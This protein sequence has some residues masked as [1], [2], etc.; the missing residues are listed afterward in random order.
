VTTSSP[1]T[2][3]LDTTLHALG[4]SG[5]LLP[6][7]L[8]APPTG[9]VNYGAAGIAYLYYR[10]ACLRSDPRLL[11]TAD[12]WANRARQESGRPDAFYNPDIEI[13][14]ETV[15][16]VALYH[17]A[18]GVHC[19]QALIS[20]AMGDGSSA[21]AT[22]QQFVAAARQPCATLDL[23]LGQASILIGCATLQEALADSAGSDTAGLTELGQETLQR[24]W[25]QLDGYG[26]LNECSELAWLGIAHGW[27][28]ILYA[29]LRWCQAGS[30]LP[31]TFQAR[32]EQ[33]AACAEPAGRGLC[34]PRLSRRGVGSREP[35]SG[36]CH[37]SAGYVFLWTLA[38]QATR[39]TE[40][41]RLA[42]GAAWHTWEDTGPNGHS[43]CCGLAGRAYALL[44][45]YRCTGDAHWLERARELGQRAVANA[46]GGDPMPYSLY[47]GTVGVALLGADLEQ[48]AA[49]CMPLFEPEG[50]PPQP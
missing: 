8:P 15:G 13:T 41:L 33:L 30:L 23:T 4:I 43:L 10:L 44:S 19:V 12:L 22:V 50:W 35:W 31:P 45:L 40:W 47:K 14:E 38:Y 24:I 17:S 20:Q 49:A 16:R 32:L 39:A 11:A 46:T 25:S 3:L 29:T 2:A 27:A 28:G 42:Q 36:W 1:G 7:G 26:P 48:P 9:S 18:S 37:G 5:P 21:R 6:R 34:W